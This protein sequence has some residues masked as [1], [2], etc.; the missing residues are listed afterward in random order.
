MKTI[1]RQAHLAGTVFD[2]V[3]G[4]AIAGHEQKLIDDDVVRVDLVLGELL[5]ETL[6]LVEREKLRYAHTHECSL[7]LCDLIKLFSFIILFD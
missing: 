7:F 6:G 3:G 5:Y 1:T 2:A 4:I